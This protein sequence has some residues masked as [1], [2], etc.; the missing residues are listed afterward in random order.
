M[1]T[2]K[3]H[4]GGRKTVCPDDIMLLEANENYTLLYLQNG[5]K[6]LVATTLKTLEQRFDVCQNFFRSGKSYIV[7]LNYLSDYQLDR[8]LIIMQNA[9]TILVSRRRKNAFQ[10]KIASND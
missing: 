5:K 7:N 3:I 2:N 6:L 10:L 8:N 4:I 9:K 1:K